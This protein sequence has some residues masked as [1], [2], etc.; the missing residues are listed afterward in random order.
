MPRGGRVKTLAE[1]KWNRWIVREDVV[2][3][4]HQ[5]Q[6]IIQQWNNV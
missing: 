4:L 3:H 1:Y 2:C 6:S 5:L